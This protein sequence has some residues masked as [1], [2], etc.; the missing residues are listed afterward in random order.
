VSSSKL[1]GSFGGFL[2]IGWVLMREH[3]H[4]RIKPQPAD[5]TRAVR[6][7]L[8]KRTAQGVVSILTQN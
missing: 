3:F 7:E 2:L 6:Q 5:S 1:Y 4:L 8:K